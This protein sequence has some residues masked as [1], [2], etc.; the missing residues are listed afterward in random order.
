MQNDRLMS[1]VLFYK[2]ADYQIFTY[3]SIFY[4]IVYIDKESLFRW[5]ICD[6]EDQKAFGTKQYNPLFALLSTIDQLYKQE[7]RPN[8]YYKG[9]ELLL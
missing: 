4:N 9:S 2:Y 8:N 1:G 7:I 3:D 6:C 5:L